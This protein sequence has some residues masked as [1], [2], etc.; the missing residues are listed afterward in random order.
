MGQLGDGTLTSH[1]TPERVTGLPV[2]IAGVGAGGHFAV[3]LG[4]DGS[5]WGW[6]DDSS[7]QLGNAP[8]SPQVTRPVSTIGAGSGI[9]QISAGPGHVLALKSD[10]TVLAWGVNRDGQLGNGT[11]A[12]VVGPVQVT[13][14]TSATQV[15]AGRAFSLAIHTVPWLTGQ[16]S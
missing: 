15:S 1:T 7:G 8:A 11:T 3:V 12:I 16:S 9:T 6:G 13:G 10:G 5:V 2:Y 4:T 14:L